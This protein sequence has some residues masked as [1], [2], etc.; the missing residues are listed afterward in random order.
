MK[1]PKTTAEWQEAVDLA[2][3]ALALESARAYGLVR[4]GPTVNSERCST[5]LREGARRG[6]VPSA[7]AVEK[8]SAALTGG[9]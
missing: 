5:I 1:Y 7:D 8:F 9:V 2:E 6:V 4:G 3:G